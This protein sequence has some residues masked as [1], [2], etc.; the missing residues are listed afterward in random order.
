MELKQVTLI[1]TDLKMSKGKMSAQVA[2]GAVEAVLKSNKNI[3]S[4]W[5]SLGQKKICLKVES[6]KDLFKYNQ[7]AKDFGLITALIKDAGHT[8]LKSGT[9]TVL[10][11]GPDFN[12]KID[13]IT[14]KL[15]MI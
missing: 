9:T 8:E 13:K 5:R 12:E 7:I 15:K 3:I 11:I 14:R 1:R 10:T 2:H 4:K 6:E